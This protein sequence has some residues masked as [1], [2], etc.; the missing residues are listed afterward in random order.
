[1]AGE[2]EVEYLGGLPLDISIR[3]QADSGKPTVVADPDGEIANIYKTIARRIAVKIA[4]RPK[5][6]SKLFPKI[7]VSK[8]S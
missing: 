5:D 8:E 2:Y 3:L 7:V 4:Q 1:M 6:T